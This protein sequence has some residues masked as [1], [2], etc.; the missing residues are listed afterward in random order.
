M[1]AGPGSETHRAGEGWG[2]LAAQR[3]SSGKWSGGESPNPVAPAAPGVEVAVFTGESET[4]R[5]RA[6]VLRAAFL[7]LLHVGADSRQESHKVQKPCLEDM[8]P[9]PQYFLQKVAYTKWNMPWKLLD[10]Q[11]PVWEF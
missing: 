6:A 4:S 2:R 11:A 9:G 3:V 8:I 1:T 7:F 10:M 5:G